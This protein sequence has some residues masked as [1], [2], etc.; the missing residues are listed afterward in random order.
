MTTA[1][2]VNKKRVLKTR[3]H[4]DEIKLVKKAKYSKS[5]LDG[6]KKTKIIPMSCATYPQILNYTV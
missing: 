5:C 6:G 4:W 2:S 1:N 3:Q